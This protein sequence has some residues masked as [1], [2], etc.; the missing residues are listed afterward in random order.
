[1]F[2]IVGLTEDPCEDPAFMV[3]VL[4]LVLTI[5]SALMSKFVLHFTDVWWG[6]DAAEFDSQCV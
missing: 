4:D 5:Q 3:I 2:N 6:A 1:M